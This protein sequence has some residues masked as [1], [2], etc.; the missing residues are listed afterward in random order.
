MRFKLVGCLS[1]A[2]ICCININSVTALDKNGDS[3][4]QLI[5][6]DDKPGRCELIAG[7]KT[8]TCNS[9]KILKKGEIYAFTYYFDGS[10]ISFFSVPSNKQLQNSDAFDVG[11]L[12]YDGKAQKLD[13]DKPGVCIKH[14]RADLTTCMANN[15]EIR[16]SKMRL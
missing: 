10:P 13:S 4:S 5:Y 8:V 3:K 14:K 16:Y 2:F 15:F 6:S 11:A 7:G 9:F 12:F 1:T